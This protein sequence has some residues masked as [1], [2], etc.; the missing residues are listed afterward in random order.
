MYHLSIEFSENRWSSFYTIALTNKQTI[1]DESITQLA[2]A[3]TTEKQDFV[4][5]KSYVCRT[6]CG[7]LVMRDGMLC[8]V[9]KFATSLL[10]VLQLWL[11]R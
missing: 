10:N 3:I 4:T 9:R 2:E 6:S 8:P 1:T 11:N 7:K 5:M